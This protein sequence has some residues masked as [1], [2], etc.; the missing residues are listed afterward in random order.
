VGLR[1]TARITDR[2]CR[3]VR[4]SVASPAGFEPA[5]YGLGNRCS[6]LLSYGD[7]CSEPYSALCL[8]ATRGV[9]EAMVRGHSRD[10]VLCLHRSLS[11]L[12]ATLTMTACGGKILDT[13]AGDGGAS[14]PPAGDPSFAPP[15]APPSEEPPAPPPSITVGEACAS[16][17]EQNAKCG[18]G[19]STTCLEDCQGTASDACNGA[20][21]ITCAGATTGERCNLP[22]ACEQSYCA[23]ARCAG[24]A[25]PD[26]C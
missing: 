21:W 17:C 8:Y 1:R 26:Y 24:R 11:Y 7:E 15:P 12:L 4:Y 22:P 2:E 13:N 20:A 18:K 16:Y 3:C 23:W 10:T 6:V 14:T 5:T 9:M 19:N 25:L